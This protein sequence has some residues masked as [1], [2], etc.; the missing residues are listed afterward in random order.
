MPTRNI[1]LTAEQDVFIEGLLDSGEYGNAGEAVRD[2][3]RALQQR[4]TEDALRLERLRL[5]LA[6]GVVDLERGA[7]SDVADEDLNGFLDSLVAQS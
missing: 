2:A 5:A 6:Q 7:A 1:R 4:R 3:I